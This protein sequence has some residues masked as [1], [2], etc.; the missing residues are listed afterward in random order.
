MKLV[1]YAD[2]SQETAAVKLFLEN[3]GLEFEEVDVSTQEGFG[4]LVKRTEQERAPGLEIKRLHG[5]GVIVGFDEKRF[6]TELRL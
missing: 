6:S 4:R 2:D 3:H 5:V 1:L